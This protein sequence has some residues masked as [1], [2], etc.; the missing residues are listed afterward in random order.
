MP[1]TWKEIQN[2]CT[3]CH[4]TG[5]VIPPHD[6]NQPIPPAI[7]CPICLGEGYLE[8]GRLKME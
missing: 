4:G 7:D 8:V 3:V 1:A 6:S 2:V 5:Q